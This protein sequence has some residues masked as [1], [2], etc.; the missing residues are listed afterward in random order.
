MS[1]SDPRATNRACE[2]PDHPGGSRSSGDPS[3]RDRR[4]GKAAGHGS[5]RVFGTH[6]IGVALWHRRTYHEWPGADLP[7][8]LYHCHRVYGRGNTVAVKSAPTLTYYYEFAP[9]L[10]A[11]HKVYSEPRDR[12]TNDLG[13]QCPMVLWA[14]DGNTYVEYGLEGGP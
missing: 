14:R 6:T 10:A 12:V 9:V 5:G 8:R 1:P 4:S 7:E 3:R 11:H 2:R 13:E